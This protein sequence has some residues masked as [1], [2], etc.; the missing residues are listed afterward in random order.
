[1]LVCLFAMLL[2]LLNEPP[3][4]ESRAI[5]SSEAPAEPKPVVQ[6]PSI[7]GPDD[8]TPKWTL[9]PAVNEADSAETPLSNNLDQGSDASNLDSAESD[10]LSKSDSFLTRYWPYALIVLALLGWWTARFRAKKAPSFKHHVIPERKQNETGPKLTGHFK[11]SNRFQQN[12][13]N[14]EPDADELPAVGKT[15]LEPQKS[16]ESQLGQDEPRL[17]DQFK[18]ATRFQKP[19]SQEGTNTNGAEKSNLNA[20]A[21][22]NDKATN[23]DESR[24]KG[25]FK[26]ATRFQ[27]PE[28]QEGTNTNGAEKSNLNATASD[29]DKATNQD[30]SRKKGQFKVATRFQKPKNKE[31]AGTIKE[32]STHKASDVRRPV[33]KSS[34][35]PADDEFELDS[36]FDFDSGVLS[37]EQRAKILEAAEILAAVKK[38][39]NDGDG[40]RFK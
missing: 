20:T 26:V 38:R 21:S 30:E 12:D 22:D 14:G 2:V 8:P 5:Q 25:Q 9:H 27:K 6:Q 19:E 29:N 4:V 28:S 24:K 17:K 3:L 10:D 16:L 23:Q 13:N 32:E 35:R 18:V 37:E 7:F 40:S 33:D 36:D 11:P 31:G 15:K 1:M 39:K 34:D